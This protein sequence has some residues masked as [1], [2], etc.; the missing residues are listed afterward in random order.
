MP[1]CATSDG[2][3]V[4]FEACVV[5]CVFPPGVC[6]GPQ[7][8]KCY[9]ISRQEPTGQ[10]R[11]DERASLVVSFMVPIAAPIQLRGLVY[12]G[13]GVSIFTFSDINCIAVQSR[14]VLKPYQID[15]YAAN[16]KTI[17][18]CVERVRF[19]LGACEHETNFVVVDDAI[20]VEDFLLGR[21]FLRAYQVL[22]DLTFMKIVVC[23]PV[24]PVWHHAHTYVGDPTL[25]VSVALDHDLV[26][27]PFEIAV[28]KTKVVITDCVF[29]MWC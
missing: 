1:I 5:I 17:K 15:L 27:Q 12:T 10:A 4:N 11:V 25:A 9:N 19:Q 14:V 18:T 28:V 6:L 26:L 16:G 3:D 13:S 21:N 2:V 29:K 24:Q 20:G 7:V 8:L 23:A 22:V